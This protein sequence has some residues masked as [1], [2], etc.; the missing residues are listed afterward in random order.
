MRINLDAKTFKN[1]VNSTRFGEVLTRA[2]MQTLL[3]RIKPNA[4]GKIDIVASSIFLTQNSKTLNNNA[5]LTDYE[6]QKLRSA[7]RQAVSALSGRDIGAIPPIC[8]LER[9]NFC[10]F[11]LKNF[12]ETYFKESYKL[13]FSSDH[14][15]VIHKMERSI[16]NGGLF[17]VAMPRGSGK[18]T[19]VETTIIWGILYGHR[20]FISLIGATETAAVEILASIKTEIET[21]DLLLEDFP[22]VCYPIKKLDGIAN[23]CKGQLS[24][25][26]RTRISWRDDEVIMP[27]VKNSLAS[28]AIIKCAG[29]TGRIRGMTHKKANGEKIRPNLVVIDDPQTSESAASYEQNKKR[30]KIL[31]SDILGLAG[32]GKKISGV[33]PCTVINKND[34][35]DQILDNAT[36]PEWNGERLKMLKS[37]PMNKDLWLQYAEI[38]AESLRINGNIT[39]ATKFYLANQSAMDFGAEASWQVRYNIDEASAI[40]NAM[41]LKIQNEQSFYS[42]YQ[43]EPMGESEENFE[44]LTI[45][46]ITS[47]INNLPEKIIPLACEKLVMFTDVQKKCLYYTV[48]AFTNDFSGAVVDYG[49]YP[50][51]KKRVFKLDEIETT[52]EQFKPHE[53]FEAALFDGLQQHHAEKMKFDYKREDGMIMHIER[54]HIDA[55]W[56]A[57]TE[58]IYQFC[59]TQQIGIIYPAHGRYIGA[60][61]KPMTEYQKK[62]G[63]VVG[64]NWILPSVAGKRAI[65][66][67]LFDSNF[68]KS[69][70]HYRLKSSV[71]EKGSLNF[72]GRNS[73]RHQDIAEQLLAEYRVVTTGRG[74]TVDEWKL[75]VNQKDNHFLDC[76]AG[77]C[78]IASILGC[79]LA[80]SQITTIQKRKKIK[81]S[82]INQKNIE[83]NSE[84]E[85]IKMHQK[86]KKIKLSEL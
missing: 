45:E 65:R 68:W 10:E 51:Q 41:N 56:G 20:N 66:H 30:L 39:E 85:E 82:E 71:A 3:K 38:R 52:L 78:V 62:Q 86:R 40:Q 48:V 14:E 53:S 77:S 29:I 6:K 46:E 25:G 67:I 83:N 16:L 26:E 43:N 33:M 54:A 63:E 81:L 84:F 35:A 37:L 64:F 47:K 7:K 8:N 44:E 31:N 18:T 12:C 32:P 1:K 70:V 5:N 11:N 15:K 79:V 72:N 58:I 19:L 9:R 73:N 55:N 75:K 4:D 17:A 2:K 21:N 36:N 74:R 22:E 23:R 34:M 57:S 42:E 76:L 60:S 61:S 27:T 49:V 69:F 80:N 24:Q 28:G 59:R 13:E 50:P